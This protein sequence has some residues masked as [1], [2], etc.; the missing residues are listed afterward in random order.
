[1]LEARQRGP[2]PTGR[3]RTATAGAYGGERTCDVFEGHCPYCG[4]ADSTPFQTVSRHG[5]GEGMTIWTRCQC[6]S[7]QM[8]TV[9]AAGGRI[10]TRGRPAADAVAGRTREPL[11]SRRRRR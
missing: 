9:D 10:V 7:L 8:R 2:G 1:M 3:G 5:T 11:G 6:G 4:W